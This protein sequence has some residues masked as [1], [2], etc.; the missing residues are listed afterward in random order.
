MKKAFLMNMLFA[1]IVLFSWSHQAYC[2]DNKVIV[3]PLSSNS[4]SIVGCWWL[5]ANG[6]QV[7]ELQS[8]TFFNDGTYIHVQNG[9]SNNS[10]WDGYEFGTYSYDTG[11]KILSVA[12]VIDRNGEVGFSHLEGQVTAEVKGNALTLSVAGDP[13]GPHTVYRVK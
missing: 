9:D 10:T 4:N 5:G 8:I 13:D 1:V 3:V 12:P 11:T 2:N 6:T 7:G